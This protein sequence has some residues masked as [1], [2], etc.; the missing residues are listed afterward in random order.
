M[1]SSTI[2]IVKRPINAPVTPSNGTPYVTTLRYPSNVSIDSAQQHY[3]C[4]Y[5]NVIEGTHTTLT[6]EN[7]L[8]YVNTTGQTNINTANLQKGALETV[9]AV[10][11][12]S[13]VFSMLKKATS[14]GASISLPVRLAAATTGAIRRSIYCCCCYTKPTISTH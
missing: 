10:V 5:I 13:S 8:G 11:G 9:G 14:L 12:A 3:T 7:T 6:N 4:F 1:S 2:P